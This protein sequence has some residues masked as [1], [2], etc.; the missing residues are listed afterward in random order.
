MYTKV[1][2]LLKLQSSCLIILLY[3]L[4]LGL[5]G[6]GYNG[7]NPWNVKAIEGELYRLCHH[8][9]VPG[10]DNLKCPIFL[11]NKCAYGFGIPDHSLPSLVVPFDIDIADASVLAAILK[12][13]LLQYCLFTLDLTKVLNFCLIVFA[14]PIRRIHYQQNGFGRSLI[15]LI[16]DIMVRQIL[17]Q[18]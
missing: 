15:L 2:L 13:V 9:G 5:I 18:W 1:I 11:Q 8:I 4:C 12:Y 3:N 16:K 17:K 10:E 7:Y 14:I 6:A